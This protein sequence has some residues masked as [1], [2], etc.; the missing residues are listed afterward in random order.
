M[1]E[2]LIYAAGERLG[3]LKDNQICQLSSQYYKKYKK[4]ITDIQMKRAWKTQGA[5]ARFMGAYNPIDQLDPEEAQAQINGLAFSREGEL[6]YYSIAVEGYSGIFLKNPLDDSEPEGHVIHNSGVRFFG[7]DYCPA[8]NK[9]VTSVSEGSL[10]RHLAIFNT[11]RAVYQLLTEGESLDDNPSWAKT[12][13]N[14]VYYDTCGIGLGKNG[15]PVDFSYRTIN[16]LDLESGE[17][18]EIISQDKKDCIKPREDGQGNLYFIRR[19]RELAKTRISGFKSLLLAPVLLVKAL[20]NW[21]NFF[22]LRYTGQTMTQGGPNPAKGKEANPEEIFIEGN[23]INAR[24]TLKENQAAGES[25]PG[26]VPKNWELVKRTPSGDMVLVAKGVL[27]YDLDQGGIV[28]SNGKYLL[29]VS[30]DGHQEHLGEVS[31]VSHLRVRK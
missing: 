17:V 26:I 2:V 31:L 14:A 29:R 18:H 11:G 10:E 24:K 1:R 7:L 23:L 12:R 22:T 16:L 13:D 9:L 20:F 25:S 30:S 6:I 3:L 5:G 28:Y 15:G 27:D 8:K 21:V 19:P 4:N